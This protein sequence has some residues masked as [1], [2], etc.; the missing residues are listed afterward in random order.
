M[1]CSPSLQK[2]GGYQVC[3]DA[4]EK[5]N[6]KILL[7]SF[8][9]VHGRTTTTSIEIDCGKGHVTYRVSFKPSDNGG[10][11]I[12]GEAVSFVSSS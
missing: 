4:A 8:L 7:Y 10:C 5:L 11:I 3:D 2:I 12:E 1:V 6:A 9:A